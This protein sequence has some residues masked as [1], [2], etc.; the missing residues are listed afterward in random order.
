MKSSKKLVS[1]LSACSV[2]LCLTIGT[3]AD[4]A[5]YDMTYTSGEG[6]SVSDVIAY[7]REKY[8]YVNRRF[9]ERLRLQVKNGDGRAY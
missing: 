2:A 3:M 8:G 7:L 4:P 1:I 9:V 6:F 5:V